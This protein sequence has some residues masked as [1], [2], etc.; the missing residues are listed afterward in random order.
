[1][2]RPIFQHI[3]KLPAGVPILLSLDYSPSSAPELEPMAEA[4]T[5]HALLAGHP[6]CF[7]S[8]WPTGNNMIA[9]IVSQICLTEF[10]D[11]VEGRDWVR[12]GFQ[13]GG[14]MFINSLRDS[15]TARYE[16]DISG[17]PLSDLPALHGIRGIGDF[18]LIVSLSAGVP[19]LKEWILYAGDVL[20]V[21]IAGGCTGVGAPQFFPYYP[22][23]LVGLMGALK[24]A[25]EYEAALLAGY[26]GEVPPVQ[27]ATRGMGPQAVAHVVIVA[28]ILLGNAGLLLTRRQR[29]EGP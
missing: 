5:R 13:A 21:P 29:R 2:V 11:A 16:L 24:G 6:V 27:R 12:L 25:A 10:P 1:V 19:G 15:L 20:D 26:P 7:I 9:R 28:F 14:E 17:V 8:L 22:M 23:Q 3:E 4:L 18:G